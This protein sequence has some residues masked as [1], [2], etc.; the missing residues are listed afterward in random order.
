[1]SRGN[2]DIAQRGID[3]F[4]RGDIAGWVEFFHEDIVWVPAPDMP[5]I[6]PSRGRAEM[7]D[8]LQSYL[9]PWDEFEVET[10][11]LEEHGDKVLWIYLQTVSQKDSGLHFETELSA[12]LEFRDDLVARVSFF[13]DRADARAALGPRE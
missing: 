11:A 2:L 9:E 12:V 7:L 4:S 10:L 8:L 6:Q 3:A 13:W 1:M 5:D